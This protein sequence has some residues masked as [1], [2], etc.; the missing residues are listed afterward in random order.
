MTTTYPYLSATESRAEWLWG[1]MP[2]YLALSRSACLE[3]VEAAVVTVTE[4]EGF[5]PNI[6]ND[7][8]WSIVLPH[9]LVYLSEDHGIDMD[10]FNGFI[11][12]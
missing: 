11:A 10:S 6:D 2:Y 1:E 9:A 4:Q 5:C 12:Y 8:A 7:G 3:A